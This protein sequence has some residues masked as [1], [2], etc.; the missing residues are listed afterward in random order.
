MH[1]PSLLVGLAIMGVG[2]VYPFMFAS[3]DG[4]ANHALA[5]ALF[6]AMSTGFVRGIGF[7]PRHPALR[8]MFSEWSCLLGLITAAA[9]RWA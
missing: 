6:W 4:R 7:L 9:L 3:A 8:R 5:A 1:W 2:S